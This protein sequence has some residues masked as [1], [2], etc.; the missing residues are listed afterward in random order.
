[1]KKTLSLIL[2]LTLVLSLVSVTGISA[3][4]YYEDAS[5][6]TIT[7]SCNQKGYGVDKAFDGNIK[8][9]WH[10]NYTAEGSEITSKDNLPISVKE[11]KKQGENEL[12]SEYIKMLGYEFD[13]AGEENDK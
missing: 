8:T 11:E 12:N 3:E 9:Y 7:A 1:M 13:M 10:S 2:A 4:E 5:S 6:W